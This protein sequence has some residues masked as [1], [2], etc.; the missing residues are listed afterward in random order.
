[1]MHVIADL[2]QMA[3][4]HLW[5]HWVL[6]GTRLSR[7][8]QLQKVSHGGT[9][10]HRRR[11]SCQVLWVNISKMIDVVALS[12]LR[13]WQG[14]FYRIIICVMGKDRKLAAAARPGYKK[15]STGHILI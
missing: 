13:H 8:R 11:G 12:L 1:M 14:Y 6:H 4:G 2:L 7:M 5:R 15:S 9:G 10:V 3:M